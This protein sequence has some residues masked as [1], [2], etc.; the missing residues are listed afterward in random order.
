MDLRLKINKPVLIVGSGFSKK[1]DTKDFFVLS[2]G[3]SLYNLDY[4]DVVISI[5]LIRMDMY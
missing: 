2:S 5:D 4:V 3:K 1:V